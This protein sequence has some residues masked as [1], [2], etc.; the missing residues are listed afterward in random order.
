MLLS[1]WAIA[2]LLLCIDFLCHAFI[3]GWYTWLTLSLFLTRIA[4]VPRS[5]WFNAYGITLFACCCIE[6]SFLYDNIGAITL[7]II[8][9]IA[10]MAYFRT[11]LLHTSLIMPLLGPTVGILFTSSLVYYFFPQGQLT[12]SFVL[13]RIFINCILFSAVMWGWRGGRSVMRTSHT[14]RKV[15]TPNRMGAS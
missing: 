10:L 1:A 14:G 2:P 6:S 5:H 7:S 15:W 4:M 13:A 9:S 3:N 8:P 12:L 11:V